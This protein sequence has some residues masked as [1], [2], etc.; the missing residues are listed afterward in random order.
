MFVLQW[1]CAL[2]LLGAAL[3]SPG[4]D[5]SKRSTVGHILKDIE[6]AVTCAGCEVCR[7]PSKVH[8]FQNRVAL[9]LDNNQE[10]TCRSAGLSASRKRCLRERDHWCLRVGWGLLLLKRLN[11]GFAKS[12]RWK[13][14]MSARVPLPAKALY[15]PTTFATWMFPPQPQL[16]SAPPSLDFATIQR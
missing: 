11:S 7:L 5:L 10:S 2:G 13:T 8:I 15:S 16:S 14:E 12:H 9:T 3:A 4:Q 1:I 6:N